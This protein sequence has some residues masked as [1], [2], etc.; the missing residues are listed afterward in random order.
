MRDPYEALGVKP[1]ASG[2]EIKRAY[3]KLAKQ[4]HP[5]STGGDKRKE[6][7]FKE[8]STA[9]DIVGDPKRR[10]EYDQMQKQGFP[11]I[12]G[13]GSA[14]FDLGDLF[15]QMFGGQAA[16]SGGSGFSYQVFSSGGP[17]GQ[18]F[19]GGFP[20]G[21]SGPFRARTGQRR[22]KAAPKPPADQ[23]IRLSNGQSATRRGNNIHSEIRLDLGQA[24]LGTVAKVATLDGQAS[25]K[26]P[27]GTSS[28]VKLRL[29]GKGGGAGSKRG[30]HFVTVHIDVPKKI[31]AEAE[32]LLQSFL[33]RTS[34]KGDT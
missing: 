9:Y 5:D 34:D 17:G 11:G 13:M 23:A 4:Y 14:G 10:A 24:I 7:R 30:D 19:T 1:D 12:G 27:P 20:F 25:V 3:R 26:I 2:D 28:G 29:R 15:A 22:K 8:I 6:E 18:G 32:Q 33:A 31:D 16:P 21:E